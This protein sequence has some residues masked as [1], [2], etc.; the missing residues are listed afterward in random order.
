MKKVWVFIILFLM[1]GCSTLHQMNANMERSN[2]VIYE[3]TQSVQKST[4]AI[5]TNTHSINES[6]AGLQGLSSPV[7]TII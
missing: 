3:N 4:D 6:T 1:A 7:G 5:Q 2:E